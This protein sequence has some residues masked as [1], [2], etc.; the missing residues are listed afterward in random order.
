MHFTTVDCRPLSDPTNGQ[1][2][3]SGTTLGKIANYTCDPKYTLFG[4]SSRVCKNDGAWSGQAATCQCMYQVLRT[5]LH[6]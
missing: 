1:V 5:I 2:V 3:I 6:Q 4:N